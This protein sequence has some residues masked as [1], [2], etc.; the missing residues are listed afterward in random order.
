M[1]NSFQ[2]QD[3]EQDG[4]LCHL[5]ESPKI[6]LRSLRKMETEIGAFDLK[7]TD[8]TLNA[9]KSLHE[10]GLEHKGIGQ[11]DLG[12]LIVIRIVSRLGIEGSWNIT[13]VTRRYSTME[14]DFH[15]RHSIN[16]SG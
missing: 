6:V 16:I 15:P 10:D 9:R 1:A 12:D 13:T 5:I 8:I 2:I 14:N 3:P 4:N 7:W 11:L